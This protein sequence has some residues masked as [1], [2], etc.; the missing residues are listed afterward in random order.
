MVK[1][2]DGQPLDGV[3][4]SPDPLFRR[5]QTL[6]QRFTD[7]DG[8]AVLDLIP[9]PDN[10]MTLWKSG[11]CPVRLSSLDIGDRRECEV[12]LRRSGGIQANVR[13]PGDHDNVEYSLR[14]EPLEVPQWDDQING[15]TNIITRPGRYGRDDLPPGRYALLVTERGWNHPWILA[16]EEVTVTDGR[17]TEV[18]IELPTHFRIQGKVTTAAGQP[19]AGKPYVLS[20]SKDDREYRLRGNLDEAGR[21]SRSA[22]V[23]GSYTISVGD[24]GALRLVGTVEIAGDVDLDLA[25]ARP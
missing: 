9:H 13:I 14:P 25:L 4:I 16:R 6:G 18:Q 15:T 12:V 2:P 7:E 5:V 20:T 10:G 8:R 19:L 24:G 17:K 11:W 22:C 1:D 21:F 23:P 3:W